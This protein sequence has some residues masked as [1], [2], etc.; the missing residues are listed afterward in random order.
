M[1]PGIIKTV[2]WLNDNGFYTT[3]S[4]DGE[5]HDF[6]CDQPIPYVHIKI[7]PPENVIKEAKRLQKLLDNIGIITVPVNNSNSEPSIEVSYNTGQEFATISLYNVK[8]I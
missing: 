1:N 5:T 2:E 8:L 6:A 7:A 4:G 3:D